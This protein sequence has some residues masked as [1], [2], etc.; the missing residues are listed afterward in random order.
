MQVLSK[1]EMKSVVGGVV[2]PISCT[3]TGCTG[4]W[5]YTSTPTGMETLDDIVTYCRTGYGSCTNGASLAPPV[6]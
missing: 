5:D 2:D 1:N 6:Q 4:S 3:C